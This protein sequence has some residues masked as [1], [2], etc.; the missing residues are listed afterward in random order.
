MVARGQ[1]HR[2]WITRVAFDEYNLSYGD[3][4]DGLDFSGSDEEGSSVNGICPTTASSGVASVKSKSANCDRVTCY[5]VG[6]VGEDT[7]LCLWDLTEDIL[8]K[9]VSTPS[10][11][12][13][14]NHSSSS[15]N[16]PYSI[17]PL[18]ASS[19]AQPT[20]LGSI[21]SSS[22]SKSDAVDN[23][24]THHSSSSSLTQRFASLNFGDKHK[25]K[26]LEKKKEKSKDTNSSSSS[27]SSSSPSQNANNPNSI[28]TPGGS[29]I[30]EF[31]KLGS[32]QCPKINEVPLIEPL[33]TKK[34]AHE[35]LT[36][37]T[38][39]EDCLVTACQ[40]GYVCTWARPGRQVSYI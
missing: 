15:C 6:S 17:T 38:F 16:T 37:L 30:C 31:V 35:R 33:V 14:A 34:I 9:V 32:S 29:R 22:S 13:N 11:S 20:S 5:R 3:V 39:L 27:T 4:P 25:N 23:G 10:S 7:Q 1:G 18:V 26:N 2:S 24:N 28:P 12:Q 36:S 40:D 19:A 21:T 8:T